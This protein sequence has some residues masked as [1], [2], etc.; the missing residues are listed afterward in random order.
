MAKLNVIWKKSTIGKSATQRA[1]IASLGLRKLNQQ[2]VHE[3]TPSIR[4]MLLKVRHLV[5]VEEIK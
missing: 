5:H 2:V 1:T 3:D 4:G